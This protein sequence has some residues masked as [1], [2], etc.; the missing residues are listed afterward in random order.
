MLQYL[1]GKFIA[2]I[3]FAGRVH[4]QQDEIAAFQSL[5]HFD[6]H[7]AAERTIR[8]V[9]ARSIDQDNLRRIVTFALRQVEDALDSVASGLRFWRDDGELFAHES[10]E[11]R[12]L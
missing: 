3:Q 9:D 10:I 4:D 1:Y 12:R 8:L 6:H 11:Q 5:P 7:L 2:L